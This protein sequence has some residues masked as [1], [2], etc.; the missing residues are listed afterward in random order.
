[1][2]L[3]QGSG[4][5]VLWCLPGSDGDAAVFAALAPWLP[6]ALSAYGIMLT[7]MHAKSPRLSVE[8]IAGECVRAIRSRPRAGPIHLMGYS[9][10]GLLAYEL[11]I[12]LSRAGHVIGFLGMVDTGLLVQLGRVTARE[13]AAAKVKRKSQTWLRHART[14]LTGPARG[15][16]FRETV[17]SKLFTKGYAY[18]AARGRVIP[19][20]LRNVNDLNLFAS[21]RYQPPPFSGTVVLIR[22]RDELRDKRW[23]LDLG[24]HSI[25]TGPL[26]IREL[27]GTH[28]DLLRTESALLGAVVSEYLAS[29]S[30]PIREQPPA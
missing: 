7:Q 27:P 6:R 26:L 20:W 5:G 11:A 22:A 19:Q 12:Q 8:E 21:T 2:I 10:G 9:F 3:N 17:I 15:R 18:L 4:D 23:T 25:P 24:W 16:W 28:R 1:M 14:M 30:V 29:H 13:S